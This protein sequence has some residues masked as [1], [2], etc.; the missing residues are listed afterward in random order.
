MYVCEFRWVS[1]CLCIH[2]HKC[3]S[4]CSVCPLWQVSNHT[5]TLDDPALF[6]VLMPWTVNARP[7]KVS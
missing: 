5:T 1:M 2:I 6:G 3:W 7:D 4:L